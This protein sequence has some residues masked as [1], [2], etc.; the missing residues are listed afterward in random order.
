M[1]QRLRDAIDSR[2]TEEQARQT[3]S[4]T[5]SA[6]ANSSGSLS[7]SQSA[8]LPRRTA[9]A[10]RST[11]RRGGAASLG[12]ALDGL[13]DNIA[14][15]AISPLRGPDP[16][17]FESEFVV[18]EDDAGNEST[19]SG[20]G[21]PKS[22]AVDGGNANKDAAAASSS[23]TTGA[24][25][26]TGSQ[27]ASTDSAVTQKMNL[28]TD[29]RVRLRRLEK[30]EARYQ[31][32]LHAYRIAHARVLSIEPFE[33]SLRENTPLTSIADPKAFTEYLNQM[34][35]KSDMITEELKRVTGERDDWKKK[36]VELE[37]REEEARNA[38]ETLKAE[39]QQL[40][41]SP[42]ASGAT[43]T[44]AEQV[45]DKDKGKSK[46][47]A[48]STSP[49]ASIASKATSI[50]GISLFPPKR[51]SEEFKSETEDLFSY[52]S[53]VPKLE[54]ELSARTEEVISL[55]SQVA[56]L[57][58]DLNVARESTEGMA[59]ALENATVELTGL[60]DARDNL[61]ADLQKKDSGSKEAMEGVSKKL[62]AKEEE[63]NK[64]RKSVEELE[65]SLK[66]KSNEIE[67][68][69]K[70]IENR[71][72]DGKEIEELKKRIGEIEGRKVEGERKI[73][74]LQSIVERLKGQNKVAQESVEKVN[75]QL[76]AK[77]EEC[78][79]LN[80][81]VNFFDIGLSGIETWPATKEALN[82]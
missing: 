18:G 66:E 68:I 3:P 6:G 76:Q 10:P 29:I 13:S 40:Q 75:A 74:I 50:P 15:T 8:R 48:V 59:R 60:R 51:K 1:F 9:E 32:L 5:S 39:N 14:S 45:Q 69:K 82:A 23:S 19:P 81:V 70:D 72:Q 7:R 77:E 2:M 30:L 36:F 46:T 22:R 57:Q 47:D 12:N 28:P 37:K 52:D 43:E 20:A 53:E 49:A 17:E 61:K 31:E 80:H 38:I 55:K 64:Y 41:K 67:Q 11:R 33:A 27:R 35:L 21:T 78:K 71:Q 79:K 26:N 42:A 4:S 63:L 58:K 54:S 24:G 56:S 16:N 62:E 44:S 25:S 65:K 73:E 34:S